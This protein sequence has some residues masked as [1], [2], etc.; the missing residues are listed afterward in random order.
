MR[1][2][3]RHVGPQFSFCAAPSDLIA[4]QVI[5]DPKTSRRIFEL[6]KDQQ[7]EL[8]FPEDQEEEALEESQA[9]L[10]RPRAQPSFDDE[11]DNEDLEFE[12]V[13]DVDYEEEFVGPHS[14]CE[15]IRAKGCSGRK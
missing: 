14:F 1:R 13:A 9:Q 8:E 7:E 5:L 15:R 2:M 12:G 6:A 10:L 4:V 3:A 11:D